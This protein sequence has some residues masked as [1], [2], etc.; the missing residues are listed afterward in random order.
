MVCACLC[1]ICGTYVCCM[2]VVLDI[3]FRDLHMLTNSL[4]LDYLLGP[5]NSSTGHPSQDLELN[6]KWRIQ[7]FPMFAI[8]WWKKKQYIELQTIC[9]FKKTKLMDFDF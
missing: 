9:F 3:K 8:S 5:Y 7:E 2:F 6:S 4:P 1:V